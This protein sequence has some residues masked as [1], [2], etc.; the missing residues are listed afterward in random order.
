MLLKGEYSLDTQPLIGVM[1]HPD[2]QPQLFKPV[3]G[4]LD[5]G[6]DYGVISAELVHQLGLRPVGVECMRMAF[7]TAWCPVFSATVV[8]PSLETQGERSFPQQRLLGGNLTHHSF[9]LVVGRAILQQ[10]LLFMA[11]GAFF[12]WID[13]DE[14]PLG[15]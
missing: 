8:L 9:D 3:L 2:S 1:V 15:W 7:G 12:Y 6:A 10:G 11:D 14:P 4:L 13:A 5:T